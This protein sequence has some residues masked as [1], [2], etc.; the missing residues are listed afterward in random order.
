VGFLYMVCF[1]CFCRCR[2]LVAL[3]LLTAYSCQTNGM[4]WV[5]STI[6]THSFP[7]TFLILGG[8]SHRRHIGG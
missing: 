1:C 8:Y 7:W 4:R 5:H 2:K 6:C 3:L